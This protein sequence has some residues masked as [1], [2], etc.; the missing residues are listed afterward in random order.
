MENLLKKSI[1][2]KRV[3]FLLVFAIIF[4]FIMYPVN[5]SAS[6]AV[7]GSVKLLE[8]LLVCATAGL[9]FDSIKEANKIMQ[10]IE[11]KYGQRPPDDSK[12][13]ILNLLGIKVIDKFGEILD[14]LIDFFKSI[15]AEEGS[16]N[17]VMEENFTPLNVTLNGS[18][19]PRDGSVLISSLY[20]E[21]LV[22]IIFCRIDPNNPSNRGLTGYIF[23]NGERRKSKLGGYAQDDWNVE[24]AYSA[25]IETLSNGGLRFSINTGGHQIY[26]ESIAS[27]YFPENSNPS[28]ESLNYYVDENSPILT[29]D[30]V[31]EED[32]P[33]VNL[34]YIPAE[35]FN[36]NINKNGK[37]EKTYKGTTDDMLNDIVQN[38]PIDDIMSDTKTSIRINPDSTVTVN[39]DPDPDPGP[40][41][42][43]TEI[44]LL[45]QILDFLKSIFEIPDDVR[46]DFNPFLNIPIK[47]KFPFS[48]PWDIKNSINTLAAD[49]KVPVWELPLLDEE[50]V[51]DFND[52]EDW[53]MITRSFLSI[54]YVVF[55]IILTRRFISGS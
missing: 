23:I 5:V 34:D 41:P 27:S 8:F 11:S 31:L 4:N 10:E 32:Y 28:Y 9:T 17:V 15:G 38:T 1:F 19:L 52:F 55:L 46:L 30:E 51:I 2:I 42:D 7:V 44:G 14:N 18:V 22:Q 47:E 50:I 53:A 20:R 13:A 36:Y 54:I 45:Q 6:V 3:L 37:L 21:N 48:L 43:P 40:D 49:K 35:K 26:T 39:P 29:D 12:N 24:I 25:S 16:N 33:N